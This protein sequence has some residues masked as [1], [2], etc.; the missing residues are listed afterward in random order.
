MMPGSVTPPSDLIG[1]L[2]MVDFTGLEPSP[3]VDRL[4][5]DGVGGIVLFDK[6]IAEPVQIGALTNAL[7]RIAADAG[8]PP[9]L[10]SMD[11]EGGPVVRLRA[12]ATH[13]PSAMAFGAAGSEALVAS[14]AGI[15]ARELRAVGVPMNFAPVL[16]VNTN[17]RNPVIGVRSYGEDPDRVGRLGAAA[18]RAMQVSGVAATVKHFPGHGDTAVDSHVRLPTVKHD[19]RRLDRVELA[20]YRAAIAA[21]CAAVM[22][23]HIIFRALDPDRPATVSPAVL[24]FL[25]ERLGFGGVIVTDS[26][27]MD[28]IRGYARPGEAAVQ[29]VLAGADIVLACGALD[30][31]REALAAVREAVASGRIPPT[32]IA[33]AV[34]RVDALKRRVKLAERATVRVEDVARRV[35]V[36][37]H[38]IVA[39]RVAEAAVTL[40]RDPGGLLPLCS[41]PV[42]VVDG[43]AG[44]GTAGRLAEALRAAGREAVC[45]PLVAG[46]APGDGVLV[47]PVG[48]ARRDTA[49]T[50]TTAARVAQ[51]A[52]ETGPLVVIA[53]GAPYVLA[54]VPPQATCLAV[55]G[56]D[57]ASLRA[58]ARALAG[59]VTAQGV[60]PVSL[61]EPGSS[62]P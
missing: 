29:A 41:G 18:I 4:I 58:G 57:P 21:G 46:Q 3:D 12:G 61:P 49:E 34:A 37:A 13:F 48:H 27:A 19:F 50:R 6:N 17:P 28:A 2:F 44:D 47:L 59:L 52:A 53:T 1:Q 38:L 33:D 26:M 40:V 14:A 42:A 7:Q 8:Q 54:D 35:G 10:I 22:T 30:A 15:T 11:Q 32:R 51:A 45:V 43:A 25:R 24:G 39:D 20:P 16:D 9:L 56:D 36:P 60:L 31:Q 5:R 62:V 55:Y 23:A